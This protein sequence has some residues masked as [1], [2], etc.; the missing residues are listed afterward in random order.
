MV[1][2]I[3]I[4]V[5]QLL[6]GWG[7]LLAT[8]ASLSL[9]PNAALLWNLDDNDEASASASASVVFGVWVLAEFMLLVL[10]VTIATVLMYC[11]RKMKPTVG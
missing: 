9:V 10:L 2:S 4:D 7:V 3:Y 5:L 11:C 1:S 6:F 8:T